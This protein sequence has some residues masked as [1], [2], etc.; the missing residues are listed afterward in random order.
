M[1]TECHA[2][3]MHHELAPS[4]Q[5]SLPTETGR[6]LLPVFILGRSGVGKHVYTTMH[7]ADY[8]SRGKS[9]MVLD[10]GRSYHKLSQTL[11]GTYLTLREEG[12]FTVEVHGSAPLT[13]CA[14]DAI[15]S[16]WTWPLPPVPR[17]DDMT[18]GLV[19]VDEALVLQRLFPQ[20]VDAVG[21][22]LRDGASFCIAGQCIEDVAAFLPLS[23]N[24][25]TI[26]LSVN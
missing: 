4:T 8:L 20:V 16:T 1:L 22:L 10:W 3:P 13:V 24:F 21:E 17:H 15:R 6:P 9:V 25:R 2:D 26:R 11:G 19:V 23:P 12:G 5:S 14:F 18:D 7:V